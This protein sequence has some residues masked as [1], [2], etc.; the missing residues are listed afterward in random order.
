VTSR[1]EFLE[2]AALGLAA[3]ALP[4]TL[5][6]APS[7]GV[8]QTVLG[9]VDADTLGLVLPHEHI[10]ASST[11]FMQ[12]WPEFFGGRE[13]FAA[14]AV[15]KL[16]QA[17]AEGVGTIVDV[18][19]ID[20]G[21]DVRLLEE[22]SRKSGVH[23][24]A[25]TGHWISPSL[26]MSAR[27]AE[28]LAR[29]FTLEIERGI[30]G[31]GI[32]PGIIKVATDRDGVTPF[33]D[34]ALR[35]AAR[36]SKATGV[37]IT[38]HTIASERTG[39]KQADIFEEEG[40]NPARVCLGHSDDS[41]DLSYL[42]GLAKRGFTLGMDHL[43]WGT[44]QG[45]GI[46]TWQQRAETVKQLIDAGFAKQIFLSNDW[47]FGISMAPTGV[48]DTLD[49]LNPDGMLFTNRK[50]IPHLQQAGMSEGVRRTLTVE[51]PRR[52]LAT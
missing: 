21:R 19:P 36:A 52:F 28:E 38:T 24:V 50:V 25:A 23:I 35:A 3:A 41:N 15:E 16:K 48:M 27:T 1:R 34:K 20:V 51:N 7:R 8:V 49:K 5:G 17:K 45:A 4:R 42:T 13:K 33:V 47:Y 2:A 9:P 31:T 30:E 10:C 26:S 18:T 37:P 11:G 40:V 14:L 29:F 12:A 32:K 44:R 43:T 22:V 6:A 46:L 39:E